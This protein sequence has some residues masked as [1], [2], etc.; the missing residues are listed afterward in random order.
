MAQIYEYLCDVYERSGQFDKAVS[1]LK[2]S[3][4]IKSRMYISDAMHDQINKLQERMNR[5]TAR[6]EHV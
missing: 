2:K 3:I 5:L 6:I 1:S 4:E